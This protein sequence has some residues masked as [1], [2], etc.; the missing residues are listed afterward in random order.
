M[1]RRLLSY[2]LLFAALVGLTACSDTASRTEEGAALDVSEAVGRPAWVDDAVIYEVFVRQFTEEGTFRAMIPRLQELKDLGVTTLWLMPIHPIGEARRK[3]TLGSPYAIR[4]FKAVNPDLGTD[5]D[6]RALVDSVHAH[7]MYL[8]IDLVANHTA[9]D[10]AWTADRP[11]WYTQN[12]EGE[13]IH[14]EGTDWTDVADLNYDN[15]EM[16]AAMIDAMRYWVEEFDI[17]GYRC[18]VAGEVPG[19]FWREA[20]AELR[21][22]KPVLMLAEWGEAEIH[23]YGFDLSYPWDTYRA[24]VATFE[25]EPVSHFV[26]AVEAELDALP[27]G[28]ERIRFTT[29]HDE[30]AWDAPPVA[31]FGS[32][33]GA[34]AASAAMMLLPGVPLLYNGQEVGSTAQT[35]LF[36]RDPLAWDENPAMTGF[37]RSLL[38]LYDDSPAL[39]EGE[40]TFLAPAAED[41]LLYERRTGDER[42]VVALNVRETAST[43]DLPAD[44]RGTS[45]RD[46]LG[47][48]MR[49]LETALTLD[50]YE[51][52][53]LRR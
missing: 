35:S 9:F 29:N 26:E 48:G 4:D 27:E 31:L 23:Q 49:D 7:G 40:V 51:T 17:D 5:A 21:D 6:F 18:D 2:V 38:A 14:P 3:G 24:L 12:E 30:T 42:V 15:P 44:L 32:P 47:G 36:E 41:V 53:V 45:W 46:G 20:I 19:D 37:Y 11:D 25:G 16:R 28:A 34:R 13:I 39:A 8:I 10:N 52:L 43:L 22:I 1:P 33:D 50:P